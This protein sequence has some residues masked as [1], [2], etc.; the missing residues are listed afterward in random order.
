MLEAAEYLDFIDRRAH[1]RE[2][3]CYSSNMC[4]KE[5]K[6]E[7]FG[8][9]FFGAARNQRYN[10]NAVAIGMYLRKSSKMMVVHMLYL[11]IYTKAQFIPRLGVHFHRTPFI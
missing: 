8:S 6:L 5:L 9:E 11:S 4:P 1:Q 10:V 3:T 7:F 2:D